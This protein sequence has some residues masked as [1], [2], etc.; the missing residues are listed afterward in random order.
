MPVV[1]DLVA[2]DEQVN[3]SKVAVN[4]YLESLQLAI[5][6]DIRYSQYCVIM[7]QKYDLAVKLLKDTLKVIMRTLYVSP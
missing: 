7:L 6:F 1:Y 2:A 3:S 4:I 5:R